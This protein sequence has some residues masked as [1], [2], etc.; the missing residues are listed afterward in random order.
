MTQEYPGSFP[1][2][3]YCNGATAPIHEA[4]TTQKHPLGQRMILEDGRVFVYAKAGGSLNPDMG[5]KNGYSQHIAFTTVALSADAGAKSIVLD[6]VVTDGP[7]GTGVIAEDEMVGGYIVIFPHSSNTFVRRIT[8]NTATTAVGGV[9]EM[10][11]G[12]D[13]PTPVAVVADVT[14]GEAMASPYA[15]VVCDSAM[16]KAVVGVATIPATTGQYLWIQTWGA[17]WLAPQSNVG[18]AYDRG[19]IFRHDGSLEK[20]GQT[21]SGT[22]SS[23]YAG[24]VLA[25]TSTAT[26]GAPFIMLQISI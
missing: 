3:I 11:I 15:Y 22:L 13:T 10:T 18:V 25:E 21:P 5:V 12:I 17:C 20:A 19:I 24:F 23:Q 7:L 2:A 14:H 16:D 9:R 26:Q 6:T 1:N 4:D 8:S